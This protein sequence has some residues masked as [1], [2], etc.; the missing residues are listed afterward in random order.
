MYVAM[1]YIRSKTVKGIEYAY[2]VKSEWDAVFKTSRQQTVKYLG[3]SADLDLEDIPVEYRQDPKI[4][5][6]ISE[7]SPKDLK[8]KK[9]LLE[10]LRDRLYLSLESGNVDN[11][12]RLYE[13]SKDFVSLQDFYDQILKPVMYDIGTKWESG[14][15][16]VVTEHVCTN[17][18]YG[19]VSVIDDRSV[20]Q[21]NREKIFLCHRKARYTDFLP[22]LL[23]RC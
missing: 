18:A 7:H 8:K 5:S 4:L 19:M 12:V 20:K 1:V 15:I 3:R 17:T 9:M 10:K 22:P 6:F 21:D 11:S 2:L 14:K 13:E 23:H 16:D